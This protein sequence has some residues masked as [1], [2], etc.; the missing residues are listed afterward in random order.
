MK[1]ERPEDGQ[2]KRHRAATI[3]VSQNTDFENNNRSP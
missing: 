1:K 3:S 2:R